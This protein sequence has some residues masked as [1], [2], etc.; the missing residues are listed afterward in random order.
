MVFGRS[1][2]P[3]VNG[4][5]N[6]EQV[7]W[8]DKGRNKIGFLKSQKIIMLVTNKRAM[9]ADE[10]S[11]NIISW[12][13]LDEVTAVV[14]NRQTRSTTSG[15]GNNLNVTHNN[16]G[17]L[18]FIKNGERVLG[19]TNIDNPDELLDRI[20]A[21]TISNISTR[22][23][24][25]PSRESLPKLQQSAPKASEDPLAILKMRFAKG[26]ITKEQFEEMKS[27]LG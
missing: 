14:S 1:K 9:Y 6:D 19:F 18:E 5:R 12:C 17:N 7:L 23:Y 26:E 24:V 13:N 27:M 10:D 15:Y 8:N 21:V 16:S 22:D 2:K 20:R 4:L 3:I 25:S 11:K